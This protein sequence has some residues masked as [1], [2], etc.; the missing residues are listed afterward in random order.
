MLNPKDETDVKLEQL[1]KV[2]AG[3]RRL[4]ALVTSVEDLS[5]KRVE[6][7][8][9]CLEALRHEIDLLVDQS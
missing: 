4:E 9:Q 7:V 1:Q 2:R 8:T 3:A 5:E 6:E